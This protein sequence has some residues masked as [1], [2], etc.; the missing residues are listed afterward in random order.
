M[1]TARKELHI[2]EP[3]VVVSF[4]TSKRDNTP[5]RQ[6]LTWRELVERFR[7]VKVRDRKDGELFSPAQFNGKRAKDNVETVSMLVLDYDHDVELK[8]ELSVWRALSCALLTY[9]T[10]SHSKAAQ[11]FRVVIPLET[12]IPA[13]LFPQLWQWAAKKSG[14]KIDSA[15]SDSSRIFYTPAKPSR[16][17][18][19]KFE[20]IEGRFLDWR[21][22]KLSHV[23]QDASQRASSVVSLESAKLPT[24]K[25]EALLANVPKF[26][27]SWERRRKDL[28]DQ[29]ASIY[30]MSLCNHATL[31]GWS[32]QEML[33][34]CVEW[35]RKHGESLPAS[36]ML[37][38]FNKYTL[39]EAHRWAAEQLAHSEQKRTSQTVLPQA[40]VENCTDVGNAKRLARMYGADLRFSKKI[41]D[42]L[43]W[44]GKRWGDDELLKVNEKAQATARSIYDEAK[45]AQDSEQRK[46]LA[47]HAAASESTMKQSAMLKEAR[48]LLA[49]QLNQFDAE[50]Y[51][52]NCNN[53]TLNL[54]T[55]TWH[56]HTR[57]HYLTR[58]APV[59]FI[60]DAQCPVILKVFRRMFNGD[61]EMISFIQRVIGSSLI[62]ERKK[63]QMFILHGA[64]DTGKTLI[65]ELL[66]I[67]LGRMDDGG[68]A[69]S[70]ETKTL[71][72][73]RFDSGSSADIASL[74]GARFVT[75][76]ESAKS[77]R[78]N[79]VLIKKL[80]GGDIEKARRL[81]ENHFEFVPEFKLWLATNFTPDVSAEDD[82]L[83]GRIALVPF[84][85]VIPTSEQVELDK[86]LKQLR[87]ELPG[88][89]RWA[90]EGCYEYMRRGLRAPR[91]V[92]VATEQYRED[93]DII[94][95]F[96]N[97]KCVLGAK[98]QILSSVLYSIF[99]GWLL[100]SGEPEMKQKRFTQ[101]L[102]I[103]KGVTT[104]REAGTG[105]KLLNGIN[106]RRSAEAELDNAEDVRNEKKSAQVERRQLNR[107]RAKNS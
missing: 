91:I 52:L 72:V 40:E 101:Q 61:D 93:M 78:L 48:S 27:D 74:R 16:K 9:T 99:S 25:L 4:F 3:I 44:D 46:A 24:K 7:I 2:I 31:A 96:I 98:H 77:Q 59:D 73:N 18:E 42:W 79:E 43:V 60:A 82:A 23:K 66:R 39:P 8:R 30:E 85:Q 14:G 12:P 63:R 41:K 47:K 83:W 53:G 87:S 103:T 19:Y 54:S 88:L 107:R 104:S 22:L 71:M 13:S 5:K 34:L 21:T 20:T 56:A 64:P 100:N 37:R 76:S 17:A 50:P 90:V 36:E 70:V 89:L 65:L 62:G 51:L 1:S 95:E 33:A 75:A 97:D 35:R 49:V 84:T 94:G 45:N 80:M 28:T 68:Y 92:M 69:G 10:F 58:L 57:E 26:K 15:A 86:L 6:S 105:R 32:A 38:K 81:Y 29:S 55:K 11:R 106:L 102:Q 67:M